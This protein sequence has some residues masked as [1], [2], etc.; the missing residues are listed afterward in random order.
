M[1]LLLHQ[2][3]EMVRD[4]LQALGMT[5]EAD[6]LTEAI[7][8]AKFVHDIDGALIIREKRDTERQRK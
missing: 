7:D 4:R 6:V 8:E 3:L 1:G 5:W 2:E